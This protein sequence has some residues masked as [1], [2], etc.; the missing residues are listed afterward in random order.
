MRKEI[1][2]DWWSYEKETTEAGNEEAAAPREEAGRG[3]AD[4]MWL[5]LALGYD[6]G[7]AAV[8]AKLD[9]FFNAL[10]QEEGP[11]K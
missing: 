10:E 5:R 6:E 8:V 1:Y 4:G 7:A 11:A 9:A 3:G 2:R